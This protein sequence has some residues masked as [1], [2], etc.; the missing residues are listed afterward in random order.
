[1]ISPL[2]AIDW[3]KTYG[4]SSYEHGSTIRQTADGGYLVTGTTSSTDGDVVGLHGPTFTDAWLIKISNFGLI[5]W[6][7]P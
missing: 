5:Q 7:R 2:G 3:Q 1:M 6:Q 4:G